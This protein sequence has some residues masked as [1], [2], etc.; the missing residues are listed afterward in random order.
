VGRN[1]KNRWRLGL[2]G[3]KGKTPSLRSSIAG[4]GIVDSSVYNYVMVRQPS[5]E[6]SLEESRKAYSLIKRARCVSC[7]GR[8][9]RASC[10][11]QCGFG[12]RVSMALRGV[13]RRLSSSR[14]FLDG[15]RPC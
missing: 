2:G 6:M 8:S 9:Q 1:G 12:R 15:E 4:E 11:R 7:A 13:L 5:Q 3:F 10:R 14:A